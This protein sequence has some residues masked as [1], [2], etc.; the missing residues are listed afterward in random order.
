[1]SIPQNSPG[2]S[3]EVASRHGRPTLVLNGQ[4]TAPLIYALTDT[5]GGR[6]SWEEIARHNIRHFAE[7]GI[8][9]FQLDLFLEH[10]WPEP[11]L[12]NI[13]LAQKQ[14]RGILDL[15][16]GA[17][18]FLRFHLR[19]PRW[20][21]KAHPEE[22]VVYL[23]TD[24]EPDLP[25]AVLLRIID[26]DPAPRRQ[27]SL[28]SQKWKT[29][30]GEQLAEFCRQLARTPEG[31]AL[32]GIHVAGGIFGEWHYWGFMSHEA[33]AGPAMT[34]YF[35]SW[36]A[37]KYTS[38][39][40]LRESWHQN[41][42]SLAT[43]TVPSIVD[44]YGAKD[45]LFR[46]PEIERHVIDY[47]ECQHDAV[48]DAILH[49]GAIIKENWPRP[50]VTGTFY[51]YF[52]ATFGR[53]A[54]G[55][56]MAVQRVL[57]S[58]AIDYLSAPATYYP[59]AFEAGDPY[60][61][62]S[63]IRS[64]HLHGKLWLDEYDQMNPLRNAWHPQYGESLQETIAKVRR[65]MLVPATQGNGFW[66]YDFGVSGFK[67]IGIT[68]RDL[69]SPEAGSQ[70]WWDDPNVMEEI[71]KVNALVKSQ[72]KQPYR[73]DADVLLVCDTDSYLYTTGDKGSDPVSNT[74]VNWATL[75]YHRAGVVLDAIHLADLNSIDLKPYRVVIFQNTFKLSEPQ[76]RHIGNEVAREGRHLVWWYAPG[77][78]DGT[79]NNATWVSEVTG[80]DL[81]RINFPAPAT[82][83]LTDSVYP[84]AAFG[85]QEKP[86]SPLFAVSDSKAEPVGFY[87]DGVSVAAARKVF[88]DHT[89]WY[90]GFSS[91]DDK[92]GTAIIAQT[93][94]HRYNTT[95]DI[96]YAGAGMLVIVTKEGGKR[97]VLLRD[98][99]KTEVDFPPGFGTAVL[100]S[101]TGKTLLL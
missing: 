29:E 50:I 46:N 4:D 67:V 101:A 55:G 16:P 61:S 36:L 17:A 83:K 2:L 9:L 88:P 5:P 1:M 34:A 15:V 8:S 73:S 47:I 84:G 96:F 76:R 39:S 38:D 37:Q 11:G 91:W 71:T 100:D 98:G 28:A 40:A 25:D 62:R 44:R 23:D 49:Y 12:F 69:R 54:A 53:D 26:E 94:A 35:R 89:A 60:R 74:G 31:N 82:I 27:T 21:T 81:K 72:F 45:G 79:T 63:L 41:D 33:D 99:T 3:S 42:V 86:L 13:E 66:F 56:H 59:D 70:G 52:F 92:V 19:A 6:W 65:N 24:Y 80:M 43:A 7:A 78:T 68:K 85:L 10:V 75:G 87:Q 64:C 32:A 20:W 95:G 22:N 58:K 57:R 51:G 90:V 48:A 30:M 14:I 77:F 93:P 97:P 18:V